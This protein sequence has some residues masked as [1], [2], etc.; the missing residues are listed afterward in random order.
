M[1]SKLAAIDR[2][3]LENFKK[4]WDKAFPA[5]VPYA[6]SFLERGNIMDPDLEDLFSEEEIELVRE[7]EKAA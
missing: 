3:D 5:G 7:K 4:D 6:D 2:K 1:K